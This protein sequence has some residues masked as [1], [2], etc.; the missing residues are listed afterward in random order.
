MM[1]FH[2]EGYQPGDPEISDLGERLASSGADGPLP[3]E[4]DVLIVGTGPAGL[5][6]AA[7]LAAFPDIR[8][9]I[10]EQRSGRLLR[11]QADGIAC[12]T[13]EMFQAFGFAERVLKEGYWVNETSFWAPADGSGGLIARTGRVDDVEHG[14]SEFPHVILN[15]ARV[16]DCFLDVMRNA[17]R[18]VEPYYDRVLTGLKISSDNDAYP[19]TVTLQRAGDGGADAIETVRSRYVVGCDGARSAVRRELGLELRGDAANQ[20]WGVMDLLAVTDFPDIRLKS[21]IQSAAE[22]TII[23]IPR[24]GGYLA[25]FYVELDEL[26]RD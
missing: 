9:C 14:L 17:P 10:V 1:Q 22:G 16:Q 5:T 13:M 18:R 3:T 12:R 24:E 11:G 7:Q 19:V 23:L 8:T 26:D 2:L 6:L 21:V 20:A 4:V 25:R 15:Q